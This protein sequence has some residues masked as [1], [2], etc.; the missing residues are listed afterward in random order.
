MVFSSLWVTYLACLG[1]GFIM[2]VPFL[3]F[4]CSFCF[5]LGC[6]VSFF[7]FFDGF[8]CFPVDGWTTRC[9]FATLVRR[10]M[11]ILLLYHRTS[12][13]NELFWH[14]FWKS[15]YYKVISLYTLHFVLFI[16]I[17]VPNCLDLLWLCSKLASPNICSLL[18]NVL[19][20]LALCIS[21]LILGLC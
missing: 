6:G 1:F 10:W 9:N 12:L 21:M 17:S 19:T 4:H 13:S 15:V 5:V 8:Q 14:P 18:K 3:P 7:F 2:I 20:I 11:H 16:F